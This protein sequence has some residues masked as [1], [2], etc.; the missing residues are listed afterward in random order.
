MDILPNDIISTII[1]YVPKKYLLNI[2]PV[3]QQWS[4]ISSSEIHFI[5]RLE[6]EYQ[7][8]KPKIPAKD[9]Y[10]KLKLF[11]TNRAKLIEIPYFIVERIYNYY[12]SSADIDKVNTTFIPYIEQFFPTN[13]DIILIP[14]TDYVDLDV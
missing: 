13:G 12:E 6:V 9:L 14:S 7:D 10:K 3:C 1:S 11:E 4:I 2:A 5:H 8:V